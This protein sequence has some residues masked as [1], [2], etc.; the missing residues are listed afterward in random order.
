MAHELPDFRNILVIH[1]GQ[2]GDVVLG[3]P[4]LRAIR[5][6]FSSSKI[7]VLCGRST[8]EIIRLADVADEEIVVDRVALRDGNRFKSIAEISK[9]VKDVRRRKFDLVIDLNSLY[10]TN[11]LGF[12]SGAMYRL[13]ENRE[14]RSLDR[15]SNFPVKPPAEDKAKHHT[16]RYLAVLEALG[17]TYIERSTIIVP[18][19]SSVA[20]ASTLLKKYGVENKVLIGL[21]LGAGHPTRRWSFENFVEIAGRLSQNKRNQVLV[22]LGPEESDMRSDAGKAFGDSTI[23]VEELSLALLVAMMYRLKILVSGDTGPMH[24]GAAVGTG[25]VLLSEIGSPSIFRPL[26]E[27][28]IVIDD[29]PLNQITVEQVEI[30]VNELLK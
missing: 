11:L 20:A 22:F 29:R 28:L 30:A 14:N 17:L 27:R 19:A 9:L 4:A 26:I 10:E 13:Y 15:L 12:L 21:F 24:L 23:V 6:H 25:I 5:D 18:P 3:L 8:S 16:D 7:T 1:F 2:L